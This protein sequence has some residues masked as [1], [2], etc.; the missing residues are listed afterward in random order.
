[1]EQFIIMQLLKLQPK[2]NASAESSGKRGK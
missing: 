2:L 1:M